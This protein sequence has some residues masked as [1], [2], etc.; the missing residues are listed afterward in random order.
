MVPT[1]V[2]DNQS[3]AGIKDANRQ[4]YGKGG[5]VVSPIRELFGPTDRWHQVNGAMGAMAK[6]YENRGKMSKYTSW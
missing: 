5:A 1:P 4:G 3:Y 6:I 2:W